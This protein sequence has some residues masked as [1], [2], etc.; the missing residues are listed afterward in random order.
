MPPHMCVLGKWSP[1]FLQNDIIHLFLLK[2]QQEFSPAL[3][4]FSFF[5]KNGISQIKAVPS[6]QVQ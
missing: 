3:L 1:M 6:A 4:I 2:G 5:H